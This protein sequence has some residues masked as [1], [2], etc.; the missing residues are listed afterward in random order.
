MVGG[1]ARSLPFAAALAGF[2]CKSN[3]E[4]YLI[5]INNSVLDVAPCLDDFEPSH[6]P[7]SRFGPREGI[8]NCVFDTLIR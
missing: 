3:L 2:Q 6:I 4:R 5:V 7:D 1:V 8:L